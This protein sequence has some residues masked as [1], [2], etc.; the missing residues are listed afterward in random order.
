MIRTLGQTKPPIPG[1]LNTILPYLPPNL[2]MYAHTGIKYWAML[3]QVLDDLAVL[4]LTIVSVILYAE[5]SV[6][7]GDDGVGKIKID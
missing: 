2:A 4:V 6:V 7:G 1:L 5:W 3:G